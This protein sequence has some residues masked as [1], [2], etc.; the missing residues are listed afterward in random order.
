[1]AT[2]DVRPILARGEEPFDTIM[3]TVAQ[4]AQGEELELFTPFEP[5][6]LFSVLGAQGFR[7]E[8]QHLQNGDVRVVFSRAD[9]DRA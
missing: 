1:M 3:Q 5:V 2:L 9:S 7:Y 6:P 8:V 4:L